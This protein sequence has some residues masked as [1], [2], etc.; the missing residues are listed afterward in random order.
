MAVENIHTL[1][2]Y[3][4]KEYAVQMATYR[5]DVLRFNFC[6]PSFLYGTQVAIETIDRTIDGRFQSLIAPL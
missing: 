2:N 4:S 3:L 6:A 1:S 5:V